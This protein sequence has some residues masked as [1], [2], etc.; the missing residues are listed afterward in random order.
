M[1]PKV[2]MIKEKTKINWTSSKLKAATHQKPPLRM[3]KNKLPVGIIYSKYTYLTEDSYSE[4]I[5]NHKSVIKKT[6][7][8]T[9]Q[10]IEKGQ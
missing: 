3:W 6:W 4:Y 2:Q 7:T 9:S 5:R 8:D 10:N 1:T